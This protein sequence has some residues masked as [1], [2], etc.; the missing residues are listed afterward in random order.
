MS[1]IIANAATEIDASHRLAQSCAVDAIM[2]ARRA[3]ELLL[4]MKAEI[5]H[6]A[7]LDWLS[8]NVSFT[9]RTAQRYMNAAAPPPKNDRLSH[10]HRRPKLTMAAAKRLVAIDAVSHRDY[11]AAHVAVVV[12]GLRSVV[13]LRDDDIDMLVHLRAQ[14]D[15]LLAQRESAGT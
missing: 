4:K 3:G 7:F 15:T 1:A 6:G 14:I 12:D 2:H 5:Q 11:V 8:T 10:S 13:A 9:V